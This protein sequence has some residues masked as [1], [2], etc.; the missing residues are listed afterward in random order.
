VIILKFSDYAK[1][2]AYPKYLNAVI[3]AK[4]VEDAAFFCKWGYLVVDDAITQTQG[5]SLRAALDKAFKRR[6]EQ[7]VHQLLE[8]D[9]RFEFLLDNA[10]VFTLA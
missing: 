1:K 6:G 5:C 2:P 8:E 10:P 7:F 4:R 9:K 3:S